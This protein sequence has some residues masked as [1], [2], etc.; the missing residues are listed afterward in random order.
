MDRAPRYNVPLPATRDHRIP[1]LMNT[2]PNRTLL[3]AALVSLCALLAVPT[4]PADEGM[5]TFDNPPAKRLAEEY[6]FEVSPAWL[7]HLQKSAVRFNNGGSGSLVSSDGLVMT[8]HH[9][10]RDLTQELSTADRDLLEE[11]FLARTQDGELK[12][13]D[14]ELDVLWSIEDVTARVKGAADGLEGAAAE[15]ARRAERSAIE[16]EARERTGLACET[17]TL[18]QG[19][20]YDLYSYKRY[21]DVRLVMAPDAAA[22]A[23]GGDVDNFEYPRYCLDVTFFR[24]YEN[25]EPLHPEHYLRWSAGG[26]AAGDLVFVAGHPGR[27]QRLDTVASLEYQRDLRLPLVLNFLWREEVK[28]LNFSERSDENRRI[29]AGDLL[30]IQNSRKAYTG[31]LG[32]LLDPELMGAKRAAESALRAAVAADPEMQASWGDAWDE[33]AGA[34]AVAAELYP[35]SIGAGTRGLR[36]ASTLYS[37]AVDIVRLAD[38]LP[39]PSAERLREYRDTGLDTLYLHLYSPAPIHDALEIRHLADGL[40]LMAESFGGDDPQVVRALAGRAPGA[41]AAECVGGTKL[42]D[43]AERKRLVEGGAEAIAASTDP[44]I[45]LARSLEGDGRA[46]RK[47]LEDEVSSVETEAYAKIAAAK[48]AIEGDSVYPDAT[49]TLRLAYGAVRGWQENGEEIPAYTHL[50]GLFEREVE[51]HAEP[52][53]ALREAWHDAQPK[54]DGDTPYNF[55]FDA[56]IIGGNSGS[57]VV[58]RGGEVVG[59]VF[60][61][62]IHSLVYNY[63]FTDDVA[64]AVAVDSRGILEA[65][66]RVWHADALV[67]ELTRDTA[68]R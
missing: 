53:F 27:T 14:L 34:Q 35:R 49:F 25:G 6:G 22:A 17:V 47:R 65:L 62:N 54:I 41:R 55:V 46:L 18:Y 63:A 33:V 23:F 4:A 50:S 10:G 67:G 26:S 43:I 48:F 31:M 42:G 12:C 11:G 68:T 58:N 8:N 51:R 66:R 38:E 24:I 60:D 2:Q 36:T 64:R 40:S 44:M 13:A 37:M 32:G 45:L 39:K 19:G 16:A 52:P 57:P 5:W 61:G 29:A 1:E 28:L 59:L 30:S 20:R 7:E 56:D 15:T 9:V 3:R 21:T